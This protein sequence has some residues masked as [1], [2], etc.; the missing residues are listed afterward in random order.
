MVSRQKAKGGPTSQGANQAIRV[1]DLKTKYPVDEETPIKLLDGNVKLYY[2]MLGRLERMSLQPN[3]LA[4]ASA[5]EKGDHMAVKNKVHS[6]K[7]A[8]GYVG[9]S[10]L[11]YVCYKIQDLHFQAAFDEMMGKYP[12]LVES[13]IEFKR[14]SRVLLAKYESKKSL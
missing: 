12:K 9:A 8:C 6:I 11:H 2:S 7:G 14:Y 4:L 10:R 13:V 5:V 1:L 3:M